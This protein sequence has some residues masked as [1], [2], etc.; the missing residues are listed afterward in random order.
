MDIYTGLHRARH[1]TVA[2]SKKDRINT[3]GECAA[4]TP[5]GRYDTLC[6]ALVLCAAIDRVVAIEIISSRPRY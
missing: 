5:A 4:K 1:G 3:V 6:M 2:R